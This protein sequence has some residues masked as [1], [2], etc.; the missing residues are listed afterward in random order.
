LADLPEDKAR[1][2]VG[3]SS[4]NWDNAVKVLPSFA[5]QLQDVVIMGSLRQRS[6]RIA[7]APGAGGEET[8]PPSASAVSRAPRSSRPVSADTIA[9]AGTADDFDDMAAPTEVDP[10]VQAQAVAT[11]RDRLRRHNLIVK[12]LARQFTDSG[13]TL[14]EDP[15]DILALITGY[16]ILGE[17]KTL[18]GRPEDERDR[19]RDALSQLLYY[20]AF[21]NRPVA[22]EVA[23]RKIAC[24]ESQISNE[25]K[26]FLNTSQIGTI[27]IEGKQFAGDTLAVTF[28]E[29]LL[30]ELR[31]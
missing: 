9:T 19:V 4:R 8:V 20:E 26:E 1:H 12:D 18:D 11:R 25:H 14:F 17:I 29:G 23:I 16:A 5:E 15:F 28:V 21:V 10:K 27:W 13:A 6:Y 31:G 7:D 30:K 24:F 2:T 22:G 3:V